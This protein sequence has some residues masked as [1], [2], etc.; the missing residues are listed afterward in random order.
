VQTGLGIFFHESVLKEVTAMDKR[1]NKFIS[2]L[3]SHRE[4]GLILILLI[5]TILLSFVTNDFLTTD[6]LF[7][8]L[9]QMTLITI[10]SVGQTLVVTSGGI[11]LSVGYIMTLTSMVLSY[12]LMF[13]VNAP[14]AI[15]VGILAAVLVGVLNGVLIT[16]LNIPA[17]IITLGMANIVKGVILIMSKGYIVS[18]NNT[19]ISDIGQANIGPIPIMVIFMPIIVAIMAYVFNKSVFGNKVKAVGGNETAAKL[20][21]INANRTRIWVY[22]LT[23]LL[24]GIAGIIVTGRLNGGNP[25]AAGTMD[26]DS[27]AAVIV[28]GTSLAGGSGT[29][30]GTMLGALLMVLIRN[31]LVL[32]QV[33]IYWQTVAIGVVIIAVCAIDGF[34]QMKKGN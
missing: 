3:G 27:V 14:L 34:T 24:C 21:G 7:N 19:F 26:M 2:V 16:K 6:N 22:T 5:M 28:G 13:G 11:D 9:K 15:I 32:L 12:L 23:G 29:V 1:S 31:G 17:F 30:V 25:N 8:V 4:N 10:I 18:L 20:S 33:N